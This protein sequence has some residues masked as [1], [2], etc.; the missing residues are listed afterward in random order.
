MATGV[1]I[2]PAVLIDNQPVQVT[3]TCHLTDGNQGNPPADFVW[4]RSQDG[5][6]QNTV[7]GSLSYTVTSLDDSD[8]YYCLPRNIHGDG[9]RGTVDLTVEGQVAYGLWLR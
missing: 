7:S 9:Q 8:S 1:S 3:L 2:P 6:T 4:T 5:W